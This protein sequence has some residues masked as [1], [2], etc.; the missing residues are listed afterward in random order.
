MSI[1]RMNL[2]EALDYINSLKTAVTLKGFPFKYS[3]FCEEHEPTV[4]V[5]NNLQSIITVM[6]PIL[7]TKGTTDVILYMSQNGRHISHK[8]RR[9]GLFVYE[10]LGLSLESGKSGE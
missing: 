5:N 2:E 4:F 6:Y 9:E 7:Q 1:K 3:E 10:L 8:S